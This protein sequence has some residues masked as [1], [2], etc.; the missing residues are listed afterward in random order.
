MDLRVPWNSGFRSGK[1]AAQSLFCKD[2]QSHTYFI[3]KQNFGADVVVA[4]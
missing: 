4:A 1:V 3:V 2:P